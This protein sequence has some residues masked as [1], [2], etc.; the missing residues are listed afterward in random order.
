MY[1]VWVP[2]SFAVL[3]APRTRSELGSLL[4]AFG[5]HMVGGAGHPA[6]GTAAKAV[7]PAGSLRRA[8]C[9][10]TVRLQMNGRRRDGRECRRRQ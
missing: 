2:L 4:K 7:P 5:P 9:A 6:Q 3:N 8:G 1:P 10:M